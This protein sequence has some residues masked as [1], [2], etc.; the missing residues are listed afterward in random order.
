MEKEISKF[1]LYATIISLGFTG[2]AIF[3][4]PYIKFVFYDLQLQVTGM[5]NTQSALLLTVYTIVTIII[6]I[7]SGALVN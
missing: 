7:P 3:I 6:M 1:K 2:G 5:T 4:I